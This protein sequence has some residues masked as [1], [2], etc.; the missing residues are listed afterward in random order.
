MVATLTAFYV[1][2]WAVASTVS[3][4]LG[5]RVSGNAQHWRESS[6]G[7]SMLAGA[8]WPLLVVG[9]VEA[10]V[11]VALAAVLRLPDK[12]VRG[13]SARTDDRVVALR[14]VSHG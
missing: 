11:F 6:L 12:G 9:V 1:T 13:W 7:W 5:K 3:A 10:G 14:V 8:V 2:F 4:C